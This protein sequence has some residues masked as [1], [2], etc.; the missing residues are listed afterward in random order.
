MEA[1]VK[2][3][4]QRFMPSAAGQDLSGLFNSSK[5]KEFRSL[6]TRNAAVCEVLQGVFLIVELVLPTR[7]TVLMFL[8]W[9]Y[10]QM[11]YMTDN[12]GHVKAAFSSLDQRISSII[13]HRLCPKVVLRGYDMLKKF[14]ADKVKPPRQ[15]GPPPTISSM[16]SGL[17]SKCSV[18]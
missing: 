3:M 16:F 1:Q 2:P 12:E 8:W 10:L 5:E 15:S 4:L 7:N 17:K 11:R 13:S 6:L 9:Q 18:M 14:L